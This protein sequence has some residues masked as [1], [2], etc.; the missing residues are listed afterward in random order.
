MPDEVKEAAPA[1]DT[2]KDTTASTSEAVSVSEGNSAAGGADAG[3]AKATAEGQT[4]LSG[5]DKQE[6][7]KQVQA[8]ADWPE[9][10]RQ[11]LAGESKED[12]K[13][14][15]RYGGPT[16]VWNA[17][18]AMRAKMASGE[19]KAVTEF[20]AEGDDKAKAEWRKANGIPET[21]DGYEPKVDG[22]V[23]GDADKPMLDS[24][25]AHAF[26]KNWTPAQFNEALG[27]YAAEQEQIKARRDEAD[28]TFRQEAEDKLR[29]EWGN[30]FRGN[31]NAIKNVLASAPAEF[32]DRLMGARLAD[33]R[34]FGDDPAALRWLASLAREINPAMTLVPNGSADIGKSIE[35]ELAEIR[36]ISRETPDKLTPA[37]E[38]RQ[39]ELIAAQMKLQSR[40]A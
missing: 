17:F 4:L 33:G 29:S 1:A 26:G 5:G 24:F 39:T 20:P 13:T 34:L 18:K 2:T 14:L 40:A 32:G 15:S 3:S 23:F 36:R 27:W 35:T 21:A 31:I 6:G 12:L 11:K 25:K 38:K 16:G 22:L 37:L 7:D 10:W 9:D 19:L 30:E 28:A 8:P